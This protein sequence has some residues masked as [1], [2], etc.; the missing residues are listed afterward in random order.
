MN[1]TITMT[2][3]DDADDLGAV[4]YIDRRAFTQYTDSMN[5]TEED[6]FGKHL[7]DLIEASDRV[8]LARYPFISFAKPADYD[9][10]KYCVEPL[11]EEHIELR[12]GQEEARTQ[13]AVSSAKHHYYLMSLCGHPEEIRYLREEL[14]MPREDLCKLRGISDP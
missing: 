7:D 11:G 6:A 12:V 3:D 8:E 4:V 1:D 10:K 2:F 5:H 9:R 14:Q 13:T